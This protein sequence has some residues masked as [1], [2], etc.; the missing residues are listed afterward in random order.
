MFAR[1]FASATH[2]NGQH[3]AHWSCTET[4]TYRDVWKN[5]TDAL[6]D[7]AGKMKASSRDS[8]SLGNYRTSHAQELG[9]SIFE[10]LIEI[11][12][13]FVCVNFVPFTR[14][15]RKASSPWMTLLLLCL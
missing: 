15:K 14:A 4:A 11:V 13:R 12:I 5:T 2:S 9:S 1:I 3:T 6:L 8:S 10:Y 7:A